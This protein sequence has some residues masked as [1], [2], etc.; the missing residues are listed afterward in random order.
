VESFNP[1]TVVAPN[2]DTKSTGR[3]FQA[4]AQSAVDKIPPGLELDALT[5]EKVFG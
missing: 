3:F 5:A 2:V 1:F 4:M